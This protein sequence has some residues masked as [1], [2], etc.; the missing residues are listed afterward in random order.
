MVLGFGP[1]IELDQDVSCRR[2]ESLFRRVDMVV[3]GFALCRWKWLELR[4][5][6]RIMF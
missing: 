4:D 6:D 1:S 2:R 5:D 3:L